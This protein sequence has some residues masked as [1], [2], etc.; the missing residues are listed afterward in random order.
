MKHTAT[1]C[2]LDNVRYFRN[3]AAEYL[4]ASRRTQYKE[5]ELFL[6]KKTIH[7]IEGLV[8]AI[9]IYEGISPT[10]VIK[11]AKQTKS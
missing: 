3:M 9:A 4:R 7:Y 11:L 8:A 5:L 1:E 10:K 2:L 6:Y